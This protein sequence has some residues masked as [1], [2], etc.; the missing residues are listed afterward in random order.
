M[1]FVQAAWPLDEAPVVYQDGHVTE[2]YP[3]CLLTAGDEHGAPTLQAI[4]I[5][6]FD[7]K[8]LVA[9]PFEV[10]HRQVARRVLPSGSFTKATLVEV[11]A[12][13]QESS[14]EAAE[15]RTIKLWVGFLREDFHEYLEVLQEFSCDYCFDPEGLLPFGPA[16]VDVAQEHFAFFSPSELEQR[17]QEEGIPDG[18]EDAQEVL[19]GEPLR[20]EEYGSVLESRMAKMEDMLF[21][22]NSTVESLAK[23]A[24]AA[25]APATATPK[26]K[27]VATA[28]ATPKSTARQTGKAPAKR[29]GATTTSSPSARAPSFPGLDGS[30]VRAALQAGVPESSLREMQRLVSQPG[31]TAKTKDLNP[32]VVPMDPLSEDEELQLVHQEEDAGLGEETSKPSPGSGALERLATIVDLLTEEKRRKATST[33]LENALEATGASTTDPPLHGAGKKAAAARRA[34]RNAFEQRPEEISS[35]IEKLMFED[36]SSSTLGPGML[37]RGLSARAWLEYRSRVGNYRSSVFGAWG[38]GGILDSLI[39]GDVAKARARAGIL[40]MMYDQAAIDKGSWTLAAELSLETPPPFSAFAAHVAPVIQDGESPFSKLLD[41]RWAETALSHLKDQDDYLTKRA[42]VN[43]AA[44]GSKDKAPG[45]ETDIEPKRKA[46]PKPKQ[47][48]QGGGT[49]PEA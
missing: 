36:L 2:G 32:N 40:I 38:V 47:K 28:K 17:R 10:W 8:L 29:P 42:A 49:N 5:C 21:A 7:S 31:K 22:L 41:S 6:T 37:P 24:K 43:K 46:R 9:I 30:V 20:A 23:S 3:V 44:R 16:L 15:D 26:R 13:Y 18:A 12:S 48:S 1:S 25:G 14:F 11:Q 27:A 39:A 34:L 4:Q 35:L 19:D 45:E 33:Q